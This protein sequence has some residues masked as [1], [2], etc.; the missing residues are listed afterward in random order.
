MASSVFYRFRSQRNESRVTFDGTG[1]SVFDLKKEIILANNLGKANDF[2]LVVLD[3]SGE[4]QCA[5]HSVS[6]HPHFGVCAEYKDDSS[7]IPRS[8]SVVV[9]RVPAR[10]GR[11]GVAR[12]LGTAGPSQAADS[13]KGTGGGGNAWHRPG[14]NMSKRFDGKEPKEE[15]KPTQQQPPPLV[16]FAFLPCCM[17]AEPSCRHPFQA[18]WR[19]KM[20][21]LLW[22]PCSKHRRRTGRRP[23]KRCHSWCRAH[24]LFLVHVVAY[25]LMNVVLPSRALALRP[26][27]QVRIP[28]S[29][30]GGAPRGGKPFQPSHHHSD[31]PLPP[32]YVCY[33]CGQK[34]SCFSVFR[35]ASDPYPR[36]SGRSLDP[37]LP[38]QQ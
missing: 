24:A 3:S 28:N 31:R 12:Y 5:S 36:C 20:K 27:S 8:S 18:E 32:S 30:R 4:G 21:R 19:T 29:S 17:Q 25:I 7:I 38:H 35:P 33:R 37:G 6:Q 15:P 10:P 16:R 9:K 14:G 11:G 34:G 1:I 2:D 22:Q 26:Y 23:R 13:A